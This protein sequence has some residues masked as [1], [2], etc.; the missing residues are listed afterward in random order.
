MYHANAWECEKIQQRPR[1]THVCRNTQSYTVHHLLC[2]VRW[3]WYVSL[4]DSNF[5]FRAYQTTAGTMRSAELRPQLPVYIFPPPSS[6][7]QAQQSTYKKRD[8]RPDGSISDQQGA[9]AFHT[10]LEILEDDEFGDDDF[11][12]QE[13]MN[14]GKI[15]FLYH[16]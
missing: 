12:D 15:G 11:K 3:D 9:S 16:H 7:K 5:Q 14:A 2:H 6:Q 4:T 1:S 10:R 8:T 13:I